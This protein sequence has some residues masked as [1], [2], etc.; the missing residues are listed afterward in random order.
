MCHDGIFYRK[1]KRGMDF[2]FEHKKAR[3]AQYSNIFQSSSLKFFSAFVEPQKLKIAVHI[4]QIQL[5][6]HGFSK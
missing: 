4:Y 5:S 1:K 2:L 3:F 6:A